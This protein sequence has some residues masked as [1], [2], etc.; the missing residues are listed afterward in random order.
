MGLKK[1]QTNNPNGRKPG[2]PNKLTGSMRERVNG[3]LDENFDTVTEAFTQL[4]PSDKLH[5][6][7]KLLAFGLP[8]LKAVEHSGEIKNK[9]E[10]LSDEQLNELVHQVLS[11]VD[12]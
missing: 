3:F 8:T 10:A 4:S 5:F 9:L 12:K 2:V 7:T 6:Y 1:G 11:A